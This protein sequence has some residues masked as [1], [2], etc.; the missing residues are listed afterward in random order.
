[1]TTVAEIVAN[2]LCI[3]CGLCEAVTKGRVQMVMTPSGSLRP[4]PLGAFSATEEQKIIASCPGLVA[5]AR[6]APDLPLDPIW[7]HHG[8]M[9][10]AWAADPTVRFEAATGG[11]LTALGQYLLHS[12]R[13]AF[14]LH[15]GP[16]PTQPMRS[17]WVIGET[18]KE[19]QDNSGSTYGPTAPLAG[20][21][22]ALERDEPF[23]V[24]A[25]PC[26]LGALHR[27]AAVDPRID[28]LVA[29]RLTMVCGGQSRLSK[30][31]SLLKEFGVEESV[32]SMFR[33]RGHGNPGATRV[34]TSN[35][36]VFEAS[37]LEIWEDEANWD[38]ETRCKFCPDALGEAADVAVADVWPGGAP[39]GEDE[40]FSGIIVRSDFGESLISGASADGYLMLGEAISPRGFDGLQPHQVRKKLALAA[41]YK[42]MA[43]AGVSPITT[44]GLRIEKLGRRLTAA[45]SAAERTGAAARIQRARS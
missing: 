36:E 9:R 22:F 6:F 25:K 29:A 16:D 3:G 39:T 32:V 27:F 14:V 44:H 43:D 31:L 15:V 18:P 4:T 23:A 11:V 5:E 30:S 28:Q 19:V 8:T 37:Y 38:V 26:D 34:E 42:G 12:E 21:E 45:E 40:G 17:K 1:M 41:R 33:Y 24:I 10:Y 7:G 13:A 2:D 35:G 20:L